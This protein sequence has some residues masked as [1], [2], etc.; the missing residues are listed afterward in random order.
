MWGKGLGGVGIAWWSGV[1]SPGVGG[2][3]S[4]CYLCMVRHHV[5]AFDGFRWACL[6]DQD[7]LDVG[8]VTSHLSRGVAVDM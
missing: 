6:R 3:L 7:Y 5:A 4:V 8:L 1:D 2:P